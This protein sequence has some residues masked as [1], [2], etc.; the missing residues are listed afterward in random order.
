LYNQ[1]EQW[2]PSGWRASRER[3]VFMDEEMMRRFRVEPRQLPVLNLSAVDGRNA[4]LEPRGLWIVG[5]NGRVD[6]YFGS[7]HFIIIDKSDRFLPPD[8]YI[9]DFSARRDLR[10]LNNETLSSA[11][12]G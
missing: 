2:L 9:A 6:L 5:A 1:I 12:A 8:W 11:L 10:K 7:R 4:S 3:T